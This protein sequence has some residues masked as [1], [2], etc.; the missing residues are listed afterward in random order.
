MTRI[1]REQLD[2]AAIDLVDQ[3][4][5]TIPLLGQPE[6]LGPRD[7][8][9]LKVKANQLQQ[10]TQFVQSHLNRWDDYISQLPQDEQ[11][12]EEEQL[13]TY[14][15]PPNSDDILGE[16]ETVLTMTGLVAKA[17]RIQNL[18]LAAVQEAE[19]E[20]ES[21]TSQASN[22]QIDQPEINQISVQTDHHGDDHLLMDVQYPPSPIPAFNQ[23][24]AHSS[25]RMG[26][27]F[28][29]DPVVHGGTSQNA[30][31]VPMFAS[32]PNPPLNP[33]PMPI[34]S[35]SHVANPIGGAIPRKE[36]APMAQ[37]NSPFHI[38]AFAGG[39]ATTTT[40]TTTTTVATMISQNR[41]NQFQDRRPFPP[42]PNSRPSNSNMGMNV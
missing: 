21:Q 6:A 34:M 27:S 7:V 5:S 41:P 36:N 25:A 16:G 2:F 8:L 1:I 10:A 32:T 29:P 13:T 22:P 24:G 28:A 40:T 3:I 11:A 17:E 39:P 37:I 9:R 19:L 15:M 38:G 23:L 18:L 26:V 14:P 20:S 35:T 31:I 33:N 42:M 30:G 12:D 4:R